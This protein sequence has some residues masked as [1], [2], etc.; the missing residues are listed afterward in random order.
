MAHTLQPPDVVA[1]ALVIALIPRTDQPTF[2]SY[3]D[4]LRDLKL[5]DGGKKRSFFIINEMDLWYPYE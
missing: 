4:T 3:N 5:K 2:Q 1:L